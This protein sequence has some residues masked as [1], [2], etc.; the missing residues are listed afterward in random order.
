M[1]S[2]GKVIE[3]SQNL[4]F[5]PEKSHGKVMEISCCSNP[6]NRVPIVLGSMW[7]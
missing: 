3:N 2:Y 5:M 4:Q 6:P 1:E 7:I